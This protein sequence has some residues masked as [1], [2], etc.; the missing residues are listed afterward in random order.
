MTDYVSIN[1]KIECDAAKIFAKKVVT[2]ALRKHPNPKIGLHIRYIC[3][4]DGSA[5]IFG[6]KHHVE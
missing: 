5:E 6:K 3:K 2:G 1:E 4:R